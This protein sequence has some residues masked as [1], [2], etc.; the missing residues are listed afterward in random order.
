MYRDRQGPV[1]GGVEPSVIYTHV[2]DV[3]Q[4]QPTRC[5]V[6]DIVAW[7]RSDSSTNALTGFIVGFNVLSHLRCAYPLRAVTGFGVME[8]LHTKRVAGGRRYYG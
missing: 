2:V 3:P 5:N 6:S 8:R 4:T 7:G 1:H